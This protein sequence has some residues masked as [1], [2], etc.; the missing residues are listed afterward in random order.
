[1]TTGKSNGRLLRATSTVAKSFYRE[2]R[3]ADYSSQDV[4][5]LVNEMMELLTH[6]ARSTASGEQRVGPTV[7]RETGLPN[8]GVLGEVLEFEL[9]HARGGQGLLVVRL[10]VE[11]PV[12][13]DDELHHA[14]HESL[15]QALRKL[16]RST[17]SV[18]RL[19]AGRYL[20]IIPRGRLDVVQPLLKRLGAAFARLEGLR[21][22]VRIGGRAAVFDGS[23]VTAADLLDR[24]DQAQPIPVFPPVGAGTGPLP[25]LP[26]QRPVVLALGGGA[27]RA[28]AH[29]GVL[30]V[31][32]R[33]GLK[34]AGV[35]GT[36]AGAIIGALHAS[37]LDEETLIE[38]F[39]SFPRSELYRTMRGAY[40]RRSARGE[41]PKN[42]ARF[43]RGSSMSFFSETERSA[44]GDDLLAQ[45]IE[46]IAG[47]DRLIQS[48][49]SPF[50]ACAT[51]LVE[52][53][54]VALSYGSLHSALRASCAIPGFFP[55]QP[56]GDRL[57]VD[58]SV[59]AEVPIGA[60]QNL[61]PQATVMAIHLARSVPQVHRYDNATDIA[62]RANALVHTQLVREQLR[63]APLLLTVPVQEVGWLSFREGEKLIAAGEQAAEEHL[64]ALLEQLTMVG[65]TV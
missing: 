32:R 21:R 57:L 63:F 18:G 1:M 33:S 7:D 31:L 56:D 42:R 61:N 58:G 50:A 24:C 59:V 16:V 48:L 15:S 44:L 22:G 34:L 54:Q 36:S 38:R 30:R 25:V 43:F 52:G 4:L 26:R 17:E 60:A 55:P 49:P 12:L 29:L 20:I 62:I 35:A 10:D 8:A 11:L 3:R 65:A 28:M 23:I 37:G 47:P 27:A 19:A 40:A 64:P 2:L 5:R 53:R 51:D 9:S 14:V 41:S 6:D 13:A 45:F 46:H 39:T